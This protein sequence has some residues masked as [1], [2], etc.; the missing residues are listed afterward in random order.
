MWPF[1]PLLSPGMRQLN[2][3]FTEA[4]NGSCSVKDA[5]KKCKSSTAAVNFFEKNKIKQNKKCKEL[6]KL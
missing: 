6:I 4:A 2:Y 5:V 3:V 1:Y